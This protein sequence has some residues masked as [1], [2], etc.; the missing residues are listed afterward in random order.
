MLDSG[1]VAGKDEGSTTGPRAA[2][3][4]GRLGACPPP[5]HR[6]SRFRARSIELRA[7]MSAQPSNDAAFTPMT[8]R[9]ISA[10]VE[11]TAGRVVELLDERVT[12][13]APAEPAA[14]PVELLTAAQLAD[15]LGVHRQTVYQR[16]VELGGER[17]GSGPLAR[18]R[19]S[20]ETARA[21]MACYAGERSQTPATGVNGS[22]EAGS[23]PAPRADPAPRRRR[24]PNGLPP[25]G[26]VLMARPRKV[27]A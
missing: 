21:A 9:V 12:A 6:L 17:V 20:L 4:R 11:R 1:G 22:P 18:W 8:E 13:T 15:A 23:D 14:D 26:S 2:W 7:A 24:S 19:F 10:I 5:V 25:A 27:R 3:W 16:A